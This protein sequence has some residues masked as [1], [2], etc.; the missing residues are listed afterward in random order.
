MQ[1]LSRISLGLTGKDVPHHQNS[2]LDASPSLSIIWNV[3]SKSS[4]MWSYYFLALDR[5]PPGAPT[6]RQVWII[7]LVFDFFHHI[8]GSLPQDFT[9]F[10]LEGV[11]NNLL[12]SSERKTKKGANSY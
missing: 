4:Y 1:T 11:M 3:H 2:N 6:K 9:R 8:S 7:Q 12:I 10:T 5:S